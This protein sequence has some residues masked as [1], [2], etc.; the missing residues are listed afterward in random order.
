[1]QLSMVND[2]GPFPKTRKVRV[3]IVGSPD[4]EF[5]GGTQ[6]TVI[7][8]S[9]LLQRSGYDVTV[10]GS[11]TFFERAG[12][13]LEEGVQYVKDSFHFDPLSWRAVQSV[14]RGVSEPLIGFL[15]PRRSYRKMKGFD[16]YYFT[17]PKFLFYVFSKY[18]K[19]RKGV[20]LANHGTYMEFLSSRKNFV[21]RSLVKFFDSVFLKYANGEGVIIQTQNYWQRDHYIER[22][23]DERK[24]QV[25]PLCIVDF[26][27]YNVKNNGTFS[28]L[29]LN[30][31]SYE[32]GAHLI[33]KIA[34]IC[35]EIDF[36][37]VG[38]GPLKGA[39]MG[40]GMGNVR[41]TGFIPEKEKI[42]EIEKC[43]VMMN[44]SDFESLSTS[45]V[46]GLASGLLILSRE[47]TSGLEFISGNVPGAVRFSDGSLE[48]IC[49]VLREIKREKERDPAKFFEAKKETR[50][51]GASVFDLNVLDKKMLEL[52]S[53]AEERVDEES[54]YENKR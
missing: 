23:I 30:R 41:V 47:R 39:I 1:M 6:V 34:N 5:Y 22:G 10:F 40:A 33:P 43:D 35:S 51:R 31:L 42:D 29:F 9:G 45:S 49:V 16:I 13:K 14:T 37:V 17:A 25:I 44:L 54:G 19:E 18:N 24:I 20:I 48:N 2:H 26:S 21:F 32:K 52:F 50:E 46:E 7:H 28:V 11:G 3:A 12:V 36:V 38:D 8:L 4:L 27:K 15:S 53:L